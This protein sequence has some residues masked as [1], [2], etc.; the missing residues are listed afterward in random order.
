MTQQDQETLAHL[1]ETQKDLE[2]Q[3]DLYMENIFRLLRESYTP[4]E[5]KGAELIA[6]CTKNMKF[7]GTAM[8]IVMNLVDPRSVPATI[9]QDLD[10]I[11]NILMAVPGPDLQ[12][13]LQP[14]T[15]WGK[16]CGAVLERHPDTKREMS[17]LYYLCDLSSPNGLGDLTSI[18]RFLDKILEFFNKNEIFPT[19]PDAFRLSVREALENM[20]TRIDGVV[21]SK[22][23]YTEKEEIGDDVAVKVLGSIADIFT[24]SCVR[25]SQ[26]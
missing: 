7:V 16:N 18:Q 2:T 20:K 9:N 8:K 14:R 23:S 10:F 22:L 5:T 4:D 21:S 11:A 25:E 26:V 3:G 15:S 17:L 19:L 1:K 13:S 6:T 12:P 24:V